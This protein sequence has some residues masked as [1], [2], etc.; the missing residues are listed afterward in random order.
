MPSVVIIRD[1]T[2]KMRVDGATIQPDGTVWH[3]GHPLVDSSKLPA[4]GLTAAQA[5]QLQLNGQWDRLAAAYAHMGD[6]GTGLVVM[7]AAEWDAAEDRRR[8]ERAARLAAL[9]PGLDQIRAARAAE[10]DYRESF[11]R[12][13][14]DE[15]NDGV[16]PPKH[17]AASSADLCRQYPAAAAYLH[18]EATSYASHYGKS[19]AGRRALERLEAGEPYEQVIAEMDSEWSA[20]AL[21]CVDN[22]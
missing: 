21:R 7:P 11:A 14:E 17:P 16:N 2:V 18:A 10:D 20:E 13:M 5:K 12:M 8:A 4:L 19:A 1:G 15:Y 3:Q 9:F 22:A 6:N